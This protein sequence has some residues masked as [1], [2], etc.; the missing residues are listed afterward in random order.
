V[1]LEG[2]AAVKSLGRNERKSAG[3]LDWIFGGASL[4]NRRWTAD[5]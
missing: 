3:E 4:Q 2:G 1:R 5:L